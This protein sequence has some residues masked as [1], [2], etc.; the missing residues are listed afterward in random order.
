MDKTLQS[1]EIT[2][3]DGARYRVRVVPDEATQD[4]DSP[5]LYD[6]ITVMVLSHRR[7]DLPCE[8]DAVEEID[9]RLCDHAY[10][11]TLGERF[12]ALEEWLKTERGATV[13]LPVWGYDH[14]ELTMRAGEENGFPDAQWDSRLLGVIYDN[15]DNREQAGIPDEKVPDLLKSAVEAYDQWAR[16]E[17]YAYVVEKKPSTTADDVRAALTAYRQTADAGDS[18]GEHNAA[19]A[20]AQR[21]G[22][23]LDAGSPTSSAWAEK[24]SCGGFYNVD[25]ALASGRYEVP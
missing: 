11:A 7:Y 15:P 2:G 18:V 1:L 6:D 12:A 8:G 23:Y 21:V 3:K 14:G 20:L 4:V 5:R 25:E 19:E 22:D 17:L 10:G 24:W 16:G 9:E 13:V